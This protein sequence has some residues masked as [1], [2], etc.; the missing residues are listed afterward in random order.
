M[1]HWKPYNC[2]Q[3]KLRGYPRGAVASVLDSN[4]I[5]SRFEI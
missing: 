1:K 2:V 3:T 5:V 4:I